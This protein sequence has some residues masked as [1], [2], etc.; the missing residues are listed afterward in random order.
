[1][2]LA[3]SPEFSDSLDSTITL[4]QYADN[5]ENCINDEHRIDRRLLQETNDK[6]QTRRNEC[7]EK[8]CSTYSPKTVSIDPNPRLLGNHSMYKIKDSVLD[9]SPSKNYQERKNDVRR[10][11]SSDSI[12]RGSYNNVILSPGCRV[13]SQ[14]CVRRSKSS[15]VKST[16]TPL[17]YIQSAKGTWTYN[18]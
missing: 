9:N 16:V 14:D 10:V 3:P 4:S 6:S 18:L 15:D 1:M 7:A 5:D 17:R 8:V 13:L 12:P 2:S 11:A